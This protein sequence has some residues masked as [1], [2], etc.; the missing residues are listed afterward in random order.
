MAWV[1]EDDF[2]SYSA[3]DLNGNNGGS[4]WGGAYSGGTGFDVSTSNPY[5][6]SS[7]SIQVN[8]DEE[9]TRALATG[10]TAGKIYMGFA[11]E[12]SPNGSN[13]SVFL[14]R[15]RDSGNNALTDCGIYEKNGQHNLRIAGVAEFPLSGLTGGVYVIVEIDFNGLGDG[16]WR[17]R[18]K[19]SGDDWSSYSSYMDPQ[20]GSFNGT[21]HHIYLNGG[22]SGLVGRWGFIS[23]SDPE[24]AQQFTQSLTANV[25]AASTMVKKIPKTLTAGVDAATSILKK[26]YMTLTAPVDVSATVAVARIYL[27]ELTAA[28]EASATIA[29]REITLVVMNAAIRVGATIANIKSFKRTLTGNVEGASTI[30]MTKRFLQTLSATVEAAADIATDF[31]YGVVLNAAIR[32]SATITRR[33]ILHITMTAAVRVWGRIRESFYK[34]KYTRQDD[35]YQRKYNE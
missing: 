5:G 30:T 7:K 27:Q 34:T 4:G 19:V 33:N 22:N 31:L 8:A 25:D 21:I 32:A 29:S 1:A 12:G 18:W 17:A 3:G 26:M 13:Q 2:D 16:K 28:I 15:L 20:G 35:D 9:M 6:G 14:V 24:G 11:P 10:C 23:A